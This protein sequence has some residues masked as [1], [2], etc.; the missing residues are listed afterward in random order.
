MQR[1]FWELALAGFAVASL[2]AGQTVTFAHDIAPM[3]YQHCASC[4]RPGESGPFP[5]L[6]YEEVKKHAPQIATVTQSRFMPPWLPQA[7]YGDF[8]DENRLTPEQIRKFA[9]WVAQGTPEG[10]EAASSRP[11]RNSPRAG[12]LG[13]PDL[14]VEAPQAFTVPAEGTDVYW[15]FVLTPADHPAAL[16]QSRGGAARREAHRASFQPDHRPLRLGA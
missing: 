14:I 4:H 10:P 5:L 7:G 13:P 16:R 6:T 8:A 9:D 1:R 2:G 3:V 12:S 11:R 15:N